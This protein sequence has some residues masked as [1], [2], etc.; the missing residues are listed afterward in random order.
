MTG[1]AP[2]AP[3]PAPPKPNQPAPAQAAPEP[4]PR[5]REPSPDAPEPTPAA[6]EP[7]HAPSNTGTEGADDDGGS[8]GD[9]S[10]EGAQSDPFADGVP[11]DPFD[12]GAPSDPFDEGARPDPFAEAT[13]ERPTTASERAAVATRRPPGASAEALAEAAAG[14]RLELL[15]S[16]FPGRVLRV[17]PDATPGRTGGRSPTLDDG[18][19]LPLD[20]PADADGVDTD[21]NEPGG[22]P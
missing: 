10:D 9:A 6:P 21:T 17:V 7:A 4:A 12:E 8:P 20:A 22:S 2:S 1:P 16:V 18:E 13:P 19:A 14:D 5:A 15:R 11:P 3:V